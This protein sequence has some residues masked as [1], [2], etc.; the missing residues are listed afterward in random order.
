MNRRAAYG[1]ISVIVLGAI[2]LTGCQPLEPE[3]P[4]EVP[5]D[6]PAEEATEAPVE[7]PTESPAEEATEAPVEAPVDP[8]ATWPIIG[9][10]GEP[11]SLDPGESASGEDSA[12]TSQ[13]YDKLVEMDIDEAGQATYIPALAE[14]WE[15]SDGQE[16]IFHLRSGVK[17]HDGTDFDAEDVVFAFERQRDPDHPYFPVKQKFYQSIFGDVIAEVEALDDLTVRFMLTAPSG[18]FLENMTNS[19]AGIPSSQAIR[20]HGDDFGRH[21]VGTGPFRFVEWEA[22]TQVILERFDDYWDGAPL[23]DGLTFRVIPDNDARFSAIAAGEIDVAAGIPP[24]KYDSGRED[25]NIDVIQMP[26]LNVGF[27]YFNVAKEP[28]D[29]RNVRLAVAHAIDKQAI[30][31][32]FYEGTGM[33]ARNVLCPA[34]WAYNWDIEPYEYNPELAME[35]LAEAGFPDGLDVELWVM[36]VS[37]PYFPQPQQIGEAFQSYLQ[38]V[39]IR[40]EIVSYDWTTYLAMT[41]AG[42]A[43][44]FMYG[45]TNVPDPHAFLYWFFGETTPKDSWDDPEV[46]RVIAEAAR[47]VDLDERTEL[48]MEAQRMLHEGLPAV[49]IAHS[50]PVVMVRAWMSGYRLNPREMHDF[51]EVVIEK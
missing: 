33:V 8:S 22:G 4:T 5:V 12:V 37:R 42:E 11:A 31:D 21:P 28:L 7:A 41:D 10:T 48:Y 47:A 40:A 49:P 1:W 25:P 6:P 43:E 26:S 2:L 20:E 46:Q 27:L 34:S 19:I 16:W 18:P 45:Q 50:E 24:V 9:R 51:T 38:A 36:P 17:F 32:A 44:I 14:S 15:T 3:A 29:D 35:L 23:P 13:I 39:G 30:V